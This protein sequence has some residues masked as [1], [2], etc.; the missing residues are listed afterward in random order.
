M[1]MPTAEQ[2]AKAF[3]AK[4]TLILGKKKIAELNRRNTPE[5]RARGI[6]HS[7]D[8]CDANMVMLAAIDPLVG[9][10]G[11]SDTW[12]EEMDARDNEEE[13]AINTLWNEAWNMAAQA[14]FYLGSE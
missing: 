11:N 14:N 12:Q 1:E 9:A 3:A 8:F 13:A 7:H 5:D 4:L 6:C 10:S 2:V